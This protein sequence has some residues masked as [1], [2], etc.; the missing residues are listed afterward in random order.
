MLISGTA[1][2]GMS[3]CNRT[4]GPLE[5]AFAYRAEDQDG[6]EQWVSEGWWRIEPGQCAR[7]Y[8]DPL[9]RRFYFYYAHAV[10][11]PSGV[12]PTEWSGKHK[13]CTK[14]KAFRAIGDDDCAGRGFETLSFR[15]I[16]IGAK[17]R[18]YALEFK[19]AAK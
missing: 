7:V 11:T 9:D 14:A 19:D 4:K 2:A 1:Q 17:T 3:F 13:F 18:D 5:A 12:T 15:K 8:N 6:I 16:D 10:G